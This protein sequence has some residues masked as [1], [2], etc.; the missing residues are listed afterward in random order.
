MSKVAVLDTN[1]QILE[2]CRPARAR[3]LLKAGKAAV[4]RR[5]PFTII[6]K[7]A[8]PPDTVKTK[9]CQV[10]VDPGSKMTGIALVDPDRNIIFAAEIEHRGQVIKKRLTD[11]SGFRR[12][13]R[14]R[15]LR[16]R[17]VRWKNRKR[18]VPIF[19]NGAW[20]MRRVKMGE[21]IKGFGDGKGWVAPSLM[22]RVYNI[23]TIV[24]R[25]C[26]LYPIST[27]AVEHV[28]FDMQLMDNPE[29]KGVEYQQGTLLGYNIRE[30]LLEKNK[31]KCAYCGGIGSQIEHI[32]PKA[33][34]GSSRVDNLTLACRHCNEKKGNRLPDE[35]KDEDLRKAV[36]KAMA[37]AKK[38]LTDAAA[39]NTIRWK[40]VETLQGTG[41]PI[42]Y[43]SGGQTKHNRTKS[44]LPK[45]H[46]FDAACVAD[47][48][49]PPA[50]HLPV[51]HIKA[52]GYG[53]R[54]LFSFSAGENKNIT[55]LVGKRNAKKKKH[56][57]NYGNRKRSGGDGFRKYDHVIMSKKARSPAPKPVPKTGEVSEDAMPKTSKTNPNQL[58]LPFP[59][60]ATPSK[61]KVS[62]RHV[63]VINCFDH[64]PKKGAPR[65]VRVEGATLEKRDP[66]I[67]GN[68]KE[69]KRFQR[70][71]GYS[72]THK[73]CC[74]GELSNLASP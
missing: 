68:T 38:P 33:K 59:S 63:G 52:K 43:G 32:I 1:Q 44:G 46:H 53:Q 11:R 47:T 27:I 28:K 39:V 73:A 4:W 54:D 49:K 31:R 72:Y 26:R 21:G 2:P 48:V 13:R 58:L 12:G 65:K 24:G 66:R 29:I 30:Y 15:N 6:L 16:Y 23:H 62:V 36:K 67:S 14:T 50:S 42:V 22:S 40:I 71:D 69:L 20:V 37:K 64:T 19:E 9:A 17:P 56:G 3:K 74:K 10:C 45:T 34:G 7:R 60:N 5:Y 41:L 35:I 70:R 51:L 8:I 55:R 18:A 57:F 25:L 61:T